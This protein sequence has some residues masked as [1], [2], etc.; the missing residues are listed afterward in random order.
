MAE[1]CPDCWNKISGSGY[2]PRCFHLSKEPDLCEECGEWKPVIIRF[3]RRYL[4]AEWFHERFN[5]LSGK[6]S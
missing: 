5:G 2:N 3:K 4:V 1:F 6:G